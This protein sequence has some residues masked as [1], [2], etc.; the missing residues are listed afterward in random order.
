MDPLS[1]APDQNQN[2]QV[3]DPLGYRQLPQNEEAEQALLGAL[4][5]DN[6]AYDQVST[7]LEPDHFYLPVHGRIFEAAR[8]L[9][10]RG[11]IA[12]PVTLKAYFEADESLTDIGG[13]QYLARLAGAAVS[14]INTEDYGRVIRDLSVRRSLIHI[15]E[16]VGRK[17]S[18]PNRAF[19]NSPR[20]ARTKAVSNHCRPR[21]PKRSRAPRRR[22]S[23]RASF[24]AC[25]PG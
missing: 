3:G 7:F 1:I 6:A 8:A 10:S 16:E 4:L 21:S 25:R 22:I 17:S 19:T 23:A 5:I 12:N 18:R 24:R 9:I 20:P 13:A 15:G 2:Q 14:I 11:Q